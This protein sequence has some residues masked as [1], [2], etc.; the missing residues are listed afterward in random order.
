[1]SANDDLYLICM[2]S[3]APLAW[4]GDHPFY[5]TARLDEAGRYTRD[6]ALRICQGELPRA[7]NAGRITAVPVRLADMEQL[8]AAAANGATDLS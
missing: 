4:K 5:Q 1:M 6:E 3:A 8:L 2:T 7:I